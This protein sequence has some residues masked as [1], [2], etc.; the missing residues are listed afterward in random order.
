M[1]KIE[2]KN[3]YSSWDEALPLGNGHFGAMGFM[4]EQDGITFIFN[5]YDVY[6]RKLTYSKRGEKLELPVQVLDVEAVANRALEAHEDPSHPAHNSYSKTMYPESYVDFYGYDR[7]GNAMIV[8]GE[9]RLLPGE[10]LSSPDRMYSALHIEKAVVDFELE[11]KVSEKQYKL[12]SNSWI[13]KDRDVFVSRIH[14]AQSGDAKSLAIRIPCAKL[15][16][17]FPVKCKDGEDVFYI[18]SSFYCNDEDRDE[19]P[20]FKYIFMIKLSGAKGDIV[21]SDAENEIVVDLRGAS[22]DFTILTTVVTELESEDIYGTALRK[23]NEASDELA[24]IEKAHSDYW[25]GFWTKSSI[26][27]PDKMLETLWYLHLY[28]LSCCSGEGARIY[29]QACGLNGLWD[30]KTPSQW[31]SQFYWDVN[32]QQS[33]WPIFTSNHLELADSFENALLSYTDMARRFAKRAYNLEGIAGD[34][35]FQFYFCMWPWCAQYLWWHYKYS[36]DEVFLRETA[37]PLFKDIITFFEGLAKEDPDT[38]EI[39]IFPDVSPEQGPLTRNSTITISTLKYM[40]TAAI[41][42]NNILGEDAGD[43]N[44]WQN[45]L[46]KMPSYSIGESP[47]YGR[48][49]KDSEWADVDLYLAHSS[50]LMPI[51]PTGEISKRTPAN[52]KEIAKNTLSYALENQGIGT[53]NFGWLAST[54]ARLGMGEDAVANLYN[55]GIGFLMRSNGMFAEE[56]ERWMQNCALTLDT[57]YHPPLVESGSATVAAVNEMLLQS[58]AGVIEVFPAVPSGRLDQ[59]SSDRFGFRKDAREKYPTSWDDCSFNNLLAEGAFEV[60]ACRKGGVTTSVKIKS[61]AGNPVSLIDPFAGEEMSIRCDG[62]DVDFE[63]SEGIVR[64]D[65]LPGAIYEMASSDQAYCP[66]EESCAAEIEYPLVTIAPSERRVFLGKDENTDYNR[67]LDGFIWE[68]YAGDVPLPEVT[69]YK[70]DFTAEGMAKNYRDALPAQYYACGKPGPDFKKINPQSVYTY[71]LGYGWKTPEGLE[72]SD[73]ESP[74]SI[75][76]DFIGST[77]ANSFV[78]D[79]RKGSYRMV[80]ISGDAL[81]PAH[82]LVKLSNGVSWDSGLIKADRYRTQIISFDQQKDGKFEIG[83]DTVDGRSWKLNAIILNKVL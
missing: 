61:L 30:I 83:F 23:L 53:H 32:I 25:S 16:E 9:I 43:L 17:V 68:Y 51:Y 15:S 26:C 10:S 74:D 1:H 60:S 33:Y 41:E 34:W 39:Y 73:R 2:Y 71:T 63:L 12:T 55:K 18:E 22:S 28:A 66:A 47:R 64:F 62:K 44:R 69:Q 6:Y 29:E 49:F 67:T 36:G 46:K 77:S 20:P 82:T 81:E 70:F 19:Y 50:V 76:R 48:H 79:L 4:D 35:P 3:S 59:K 37:Y 21:G 56:T 58:Y 5:H 72:Y 24:L 11:N 52:I 31:G 75:R 42:A 45:L 80:I 40:V 54:A 7:P 65:T 38:G 27:I 57:A 14:Q 8:S 13:A 78:M